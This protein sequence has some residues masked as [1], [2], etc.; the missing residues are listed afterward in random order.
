MFP[1]RALARSAGISSKTIRHWESVGILPASRRNEHGYRLYPAS[2]LERIRFIQKAKSIGFS[3]AEIHKLTESAKLK[4]TACA[5]AVVWVGNKIAA[6][7]QQIASLTK[8]HKRLVEYQSQWNGKPCP[9]LSDSEV[10]CLIE[11]LPLNIHKED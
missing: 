6:V 2:T 9:P 3:L 10:C 8:L 1:I 7:E 5:D 4:G 11:A